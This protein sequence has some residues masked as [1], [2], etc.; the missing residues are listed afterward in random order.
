MTILTCKVG[1]RPHSLWILAAV[2]RLSLAVPRVTVTSGTDGTH[3]IGSKHSSGDAVDFRTKNFPTL[4]SKQRFVVALQQELGPE[5][6]VFLE[7]L[8]TPNEHCHVEYD[9][10]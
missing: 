3:R 5:Y 6:Q 7:G 4:A 9:P 1:V 10:A 2:S 8:G